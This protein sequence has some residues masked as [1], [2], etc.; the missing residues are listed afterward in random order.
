MKNNFLES[1]YKA[2]NWMLSREKLHDCQTCK[3]SRKVVLVK[4]L[5]GFQSF[6][7][8]IMQEMLNIIF[9]LMLSIHGDYN[10]LRN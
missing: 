6:L 4:V 9:Q 1:S 3:V 5:S 2:V 8:A 10:N 7:G